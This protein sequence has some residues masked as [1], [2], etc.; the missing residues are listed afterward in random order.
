MVEEVEDKELRQLQ[1][2]FKYNIS[3]DEILSGRL[4]VF[5]ANG[6]AYL[7]Q[8]RIGCY[9]CKNGRTCRSVQLVI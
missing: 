5:M 3:T 4:K 8:R 1:A 6:Y 7:D 9:V 2:Y